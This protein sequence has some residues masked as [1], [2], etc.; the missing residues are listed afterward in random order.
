MCMCVFRNCSIQ[1][2]MMGINSCCYTFCDERTLHL[3]L[4]FFS[5]TQYV[6]ITSTIGH[7]NFVLPSNSEF[8]VCLY[9]RMTEQHKYV[10][11]SDKTSPFVWIR[12]GLK[13]NKWTN[14]QTQF[15]AAFLTML[16]GILSEHSYRRSKGNP[17]RER[18][19][20]LGACEF[21]KPSLS[22]CFCRLITH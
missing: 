21:A 18:A 15:C 5:R 3:V 10:D 11:G 16:F 17:L 13:T 7:L 19:V 12:L 4:S 22:V 2:I 14:K 8:I 1:L 6:I 20:E 9:S